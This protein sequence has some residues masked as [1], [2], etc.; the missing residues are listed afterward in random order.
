M[1]SLE[2]KIPPPL[3]VAALALGM[4]GVASLGPYFAT[5]AI[6]RLAGCAVFVTAGVFFSV[7]AIISFRRARTTLNP[8]KPET[9]STLVA[10]GIY[11]FTRNPMYVALS[12]F[13]FAW[14]I[15]LSSA[16]TLLGPAAF[17]LYIRRFQIL[18]EERALMK[19]FGREYEAYCAKVRRWL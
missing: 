5:T 15:F 12:F 3:I 19:L 1:K 11:R 14:A 6:L 17:V 2:L 16:W 8:T 13:L 18:P 10:S 9:T 7:A 4:W